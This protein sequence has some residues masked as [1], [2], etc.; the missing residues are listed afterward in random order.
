MNLEEY[1]KFANFAVNVYT[2]TSGYKPRLPA[3]VGT[4][5]GLLTGIG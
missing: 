5:S 1:Y 3:F 4:V 2:Y